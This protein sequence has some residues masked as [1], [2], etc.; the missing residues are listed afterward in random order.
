M[1][2]I[3]LV[4]HGE[5]AMN[6]TPTLSHRLADLPLTERGHQQAQLVADRLGGQRLA[7]IVTSPLRR[8]R[9]TADCIAARTGAA[10]RI[11]DALREIDC[12]ELDG[13][14]DED[15][16]T[17]TREIY[18]RWRLG[19]WSASFPGGESGRQLVDRLAGVVAELAETYPRDDVAVVGH[20]GL[21]W[22]AVPR[23]C[24]LPIEAPTELRNTSVTVLRYHEGRLTC[25][26][27]G[28]VAHLG[29]D[30]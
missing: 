5:S 19:D 28:C 18:R 25:E 21:F 24:G 17:A 8:A 29:Q 23:L 1:A 15:A 12:G 2:A 10:V 9:Q 13:R 22:F 16:W 14:S 11:E 4:R 30:G 20:G 6:V 27:W 26:L 3:Y 7:G